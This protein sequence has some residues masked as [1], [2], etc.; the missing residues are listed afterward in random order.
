MCLFLYMTCTWL[1][2]P[3]WTH[4]ATYAAYEWHWVI[5]E[6]S[7]LTWLSCSSVL[8]MPLHPSAR[9]HSFHCFF[10]CSVLI[11]SLPCTN[12]YSYTVC[13]RTHTHL[14]SL[15]EPLLRRQAWVEG[16]LGSG[17]RYCRTERWSILDHCSS[18]EQWGEQ[19]QS[20][21]V[22]MQAVLQSSS[23][24]CLDFRPKVSFSL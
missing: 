8:Y 16:P 6:P 12:N 11:S 23:V 3:T 7:T 24:R 18:T 19:N 4:R 5:L 14:L 2:S 21:L 9:Y 10:P 22:R 15:C 20:I 1:S 13:S 17:S